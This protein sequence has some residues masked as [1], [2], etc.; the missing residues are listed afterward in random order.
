[1]KALIATITMVFVIGG[2]SVAFGTTSEEETRKIKTENREILSAEQVELFK[3]G[4]LAETV[5]QPV[6]SST[7]QLINTELLKQSKEEN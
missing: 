6:Y 5:V 3:E 7:D 4:R 2:Q 1:M